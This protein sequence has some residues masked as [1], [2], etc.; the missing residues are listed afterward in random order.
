MR[1]RMGLSNIGLDVGDDAGFC[2]F[3]KFYLLEIGDLGLELAERASH[4]ESRL[5]A[6]TLK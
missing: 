3:G 4:L 2:D 5:P 1:S 6:Y